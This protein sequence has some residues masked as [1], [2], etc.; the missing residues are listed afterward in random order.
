MMTLRE[1]VADSLAND[2]TSTDEELVAHWI[3]NGVSAADAARYIRRR[4][5]FLQLALPTVDDLG[6]ASDDGANGG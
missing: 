2:E 6:N 1:F 5:L 3:A 4:A